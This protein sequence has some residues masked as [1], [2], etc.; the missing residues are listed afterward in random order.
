M[1][2]KKSITCNK[3]I[4]I[5]KPFQDVFD[6]SNVGAGLQISDALPQ[7][8]NEHAPYFSLKPE[9]FTLQMSPTEK[10]FS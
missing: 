2:I 3:D 8:R 9:T 10:A 5:T 4:S 7:Y 1:K 6:E